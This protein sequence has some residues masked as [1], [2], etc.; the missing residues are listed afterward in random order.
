MIS[1]E[2][3]FVLLTNNIDINARACSSRVVV[4]VRQRSSGG[5][6]KLSPLA[7]ALEAPR[8]VG[9]EGLRE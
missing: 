9:L 2:E 5:A 8:R 6:R 1:N 3:D 7:D 4:R